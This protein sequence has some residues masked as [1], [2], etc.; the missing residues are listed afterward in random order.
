MRRLRLGL[1]RIAQETNALSPLPSTFEDF[2]RFQWLE[3]EELLQA[4]SSGGDEAPGFLRNAELSG[5][6]RGAREI[7]PGVEIVPLF[8]AWAI[9]GGKLDGPTL[10]GFQERLEQGLRAAGALDGLLVSMHG[11]LQAEGE[12]DPEGLLLEQAQALLGGAPIAATFDLHGQL[13]ARM[14]RA[15]TV[16]LGYQTNPHR[17]HFSIGRK[18]GALLVRTI[19]GQIRPVSA[20]RSLPMVLGGGTTLD[21]LSPMRGV[22]G[23]MKA[24][25]KQRGVLGAS[26]FTCHLWNDAP[27]LGWATHVITDGEPERA[28]ALAQELAERCWEVRHQGPPE[29]PGPE[30]AI[31]QARRAVFAR[32][33]GT[34]CISDASDM[35]GAGAVGE[36]TLLLGP[37]LEQARDL[38]VLAPIRDDQ[39]L[40]SIWQQAEGSRVQT[41]VGGR[42]APQLCAPL[43]IEGRL[44]R[45]AELPAIGRVAVL[46]LGHLQLVLTQAPPLAMKPSFYSM[47]GLSPWRADICVVKSLFPFRLYFLL[48]NRK[49]IYAKTR[50]M[51]DFDAWKHIPRQGPVH[52]NVALDAWEAEDRLRR[53]L[54]RAD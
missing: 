24:M 17:D 26:V 25:Q 1:L 27:D 16:L 47:L 41:A 33:L 30:E 5:M 38:K 6:V 50:G 8:S 37:L 20:W 45:K 18:A 42:L 52:P 39:A 19:R 10:R 44:R 48:H 35:V 14:V 13:T 3:G 4:T 53:G 21:F 23:R 15:T 43:P 49:T 32:R 9:P 11:S 22:F 51:T 28:E 31:D 34:V 54:A 40:A 2:R 7:E 46:D 29:L 12:D 36:S